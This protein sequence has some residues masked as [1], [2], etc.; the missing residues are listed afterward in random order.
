V[1][2]APTQPPVAGVIHDIGYQRY[3]GPRLGRAYATRSLYVHALRTAFG[4]GRTGWGK[5]AT[6]FI[7]SLLLAVA[8]VLVAVRSQI[9]EPVM[10]YSSF[11]SELNVLVL[12]Y[13]A[14]A[15]PELVSRDLRSGVL[16]LYF[17]RPLTRS[18]YPVAKWLALVS[19]V[20]L[21]MAGPLLVMFLGGAFSLDSMSAVWDETIEFSKGLVIAAV[22]ALLFASISLLLSSL[23]GRR[24]VAMALTAA[25]FILTTPVVGILHAIA[26]VQ[27]SASESF[28]GELTGGPLQLTQ[29]S[30]LASPSTQVS[31]VE[32][33]LFQPESTMV[34]PFGPLYGVVVLGITAACVLLTL[35]R[36]RK[37]AR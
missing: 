14:I 3:T 28:T 37:V 22:V 11:P 25:V 27:A 18:D 2:S 9:G 31:G 10:D 4:L 7:P 36:Y 8:A 6:W 26:Y 34:G 32:A 1:P 17:S 33:W 24:A 23:S 13:C 5:V 21:V 29:L 35:L 12:I 20:F 15:A 16:P 19:A 30:F